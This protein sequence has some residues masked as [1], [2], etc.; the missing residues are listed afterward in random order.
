MADDNISLGMFD[1]QGIP[2]APR[3]IPQI[4]VT[5]DIDTNGIVK[6]SAKDLGT[7]IEQKIT[8]T[9]GALTELE[10]KKMIKAKTK[11]Y[12]GRNFVVGSDLA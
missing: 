1:L 6:V 4:E 2:P 8:V 7:G 5:F 10:I 12:T 9:G 3:S 11:P